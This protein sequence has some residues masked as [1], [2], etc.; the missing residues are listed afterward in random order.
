MP[1]QRQG[2]HPPAPLQTLGVRFRE[3]L[4][5]HR[6]LLRALTV[7]QQYQSHSLKVIDSSVV[8]CSSQVS[9]LPTEVH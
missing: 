5:L 3:E 2:Y 8:C 7:T 1:E 4:G 9:R 6:S